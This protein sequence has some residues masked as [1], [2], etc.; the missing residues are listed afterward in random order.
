MGNHPSLYS[1][2]HPLCV[3]LLGHRMLCSRL[4][5]RLTG[6]KCILGR[7]TGKNVFYSIGL[8][9]IS[10]GHLILSDAETLSYYTSTEIKCEGYIGVTVKMTNN[11]LILCYSIT[12]RTAFAILTNSTAC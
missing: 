2:S 5:G 12:R 8:P 4:W 1:K 11:L 6:V 10:Y 9:A 7:D 3:F